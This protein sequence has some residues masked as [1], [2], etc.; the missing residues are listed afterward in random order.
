MCETEA[1]GVV[2]RYCPL[3]GAAAGAADAWGAALDAQLAVLRATVALREPF[4]R[5]VATHAALRLVR[6]PGW[7]GE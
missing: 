3:E 5:R 6:V 7:A 1:H 2:L 4:R